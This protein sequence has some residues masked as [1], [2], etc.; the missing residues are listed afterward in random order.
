MPGNINSTRYPDPVVSQHIVKKLL[1]CPETGWP[2]DQTAVQ[3][4]RHHFEAVS[5]STYSTSNASSGILI[6][7]LS[8]M[9]KPWAV[10]NRMSLVSR[11]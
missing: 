5:P 8:R 11:V 10:A 1:D 7:L 3:A 2:P 4:Y 9:A 6:E